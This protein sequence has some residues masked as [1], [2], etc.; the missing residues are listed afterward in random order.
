MSDRRATHLH[1]A[2][3][4][5]GDCC[6]SPNSS[7]TCDFARINRVNM[8]QDEGFGGWV[9]HRSIEINKRKRKDVQGEYELSV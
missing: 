3:S 9:E 6:T 8:E 7:H 2:T 4:H 5:L 1:I